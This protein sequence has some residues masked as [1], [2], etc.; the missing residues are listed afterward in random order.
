MLS[1]VFHT[2]LKAIIRVETKNEGAWNLVAIEN[3]DSPTEFNIT[4]VLCEWLRLEIHDTN[5]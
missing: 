3:F 1:I 5:A 2:M 4:S